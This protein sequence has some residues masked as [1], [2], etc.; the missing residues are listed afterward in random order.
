[1]TGAT[2]TGKTVTLLVLAEGF[3]R[4]GVPVFVADVKGDVAGLA[5]PGVPGERIRERAAKVGP[6]GYVS[7]ASPPWTSRTCSARS[8]PAAAW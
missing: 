2:G 8:S 5:M 6:E 7:E 4:M 3:S 1:V